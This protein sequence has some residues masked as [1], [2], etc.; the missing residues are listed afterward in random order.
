MSS[1]TKDPGFTS[2][3][4]ALATATVE[5][6]PDD[7]SSL[8][9][10]YALPSNNAQ[11]VSQLNAAITGTPDWVKDLPDA[12]QSYY[13]SIGGAVASIINKDTSSGAAPGADK[14]GILAAGAAAAVAVGV[15]MAL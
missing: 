8:S 15:M 7:L 5:V 2:F 14:A 6:S 4:V 13:H 3:A 12:Q 10:L 9:Q 1:L 11:A